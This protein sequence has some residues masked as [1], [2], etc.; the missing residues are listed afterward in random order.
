VGDPDPV[1][2]QAARGVRVVR[3]GLLSRERWGRKSGAARARGLQR[4]HVICTR[5]ALDGQIE[6]IRFV[7]LSRRVGR[8][9]HEAAESDTMCA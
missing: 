1:E 6:P 3:H 8:G 9:W 7:T 4:R 2:G 5:R